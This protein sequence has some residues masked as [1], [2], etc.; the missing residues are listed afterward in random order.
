M[1]IELKNILCAVDF[2]ETS[3]HALRYARALASAHDSRLTLF[4][5]VQMPSLASFP[6]LFDRNAADQYDEYGVP[7]LR[8]SIV[9]MDAI[10]GAASE[11]LEELLEICRGDAIECSGE[12]AVGDPYSEL[13]KKAAEDAFDLIVMGTHG[14]SGLKELLIGSVAEKVV[15]KAPCPVLTVKLPED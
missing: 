15:R 2:S 4:H 12:V 13:V 9:N 8:S 6:T 10:R 7:Q 5:V 14:Q 3:D 11:K 1:S